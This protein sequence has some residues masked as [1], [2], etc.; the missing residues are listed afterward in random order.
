MVELV[1]F[2]V[3]IFALRPLHPYVYFHSSYKV[4]L[5]GSVASLNNVEFSFTYNWDPTN[6]L[7]SHDTVSSTGSS[8]QAATK[9][10][11]HLSFGWQ[12]TPCAYFLPCTGGVCRDEADRNQNMMVNS[13]YAQLPGRRLCAAQW[14]KHGVWGTG[15]VSRCC[16]A[17]AFSSASCISAQY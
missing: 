9:D 1:A 10:S 4:W 12:F 5:G 16:S 14:G 3:S 2:P 17:L 8:S 15:R 11:N 6:L 13:W 7:K